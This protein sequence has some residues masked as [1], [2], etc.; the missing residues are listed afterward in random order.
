M[1]L[2]LSRILAGCEHGWLSQC[3]EKNLNRIST[4]DGH[5]C[6][7]IKTFLTKGAKAAE[8]PRSGGSVN[9]NIRRLT[10]P[11]PS[12]A[13]GCEL[14]GNQFSLSRAVPISWGGTAKS[15]SY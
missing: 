12:A 4:T 15:D 14:D 2:P 5:G 7:R 9:G 3:R 1:L 10:P 11:S 8:S 6:E 13:C